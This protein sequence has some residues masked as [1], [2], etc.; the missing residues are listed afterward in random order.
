MA[1]PILT[2]LTTLMYLA[3]AILLYRG[4]VTADSKKQTT[5][6]ILTIIGLLSHGGLIAGGWQASGSLE[7]GWL[8]ILSACAW[9]MV[10]V[11]VGGRIF[12]QQ[13]FDAALVALPLAAVVVAADGFLPLR[14]IP[15][16][17]ISTETKIHVISSVL[18]FGLLGIGAVYAVFIAVLDHF[19]RRHRLTALVRALPALD[20]LERLLARLV[21][22]GELLLTVSLI[23]GFLFI[24]NLFDQHLIHKTVLSLLAWIVFG[25][26]LLGRWRFGW[27]GQRMV[28]LTLAGMVLL[29]LSYF[30]SKLVLEQILG[31]SWQV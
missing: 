20:V 19:L 31:T 28:R 15:L 3:A 8:H 9:V 6:L 27:R 18:A 22:L 10:L 24:E 16:E 7:V 11:V 30:G 26:L 23:S 13:V 21:M 29:L 17:S 14:G 4:L 12:R 5:A 25:V 2:T 1:T